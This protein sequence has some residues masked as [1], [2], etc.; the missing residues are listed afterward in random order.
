MSRLRGRY[1]DVVVVA[2]AAAAED[3][4]AGV[5]VGESLGVVFGEVVAGIVAGIVAGAVLTS[6][7]PPVS[8]NWPE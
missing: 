5:F 3:V 8:E 1:W 2:E 4:A 7:E 6:F